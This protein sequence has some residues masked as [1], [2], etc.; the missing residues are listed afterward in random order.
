MPYNVVEDLAKVPAHMTLLDALRTPAQFENLSRVLQ[1]PLT[2]RIEQRLPLSKESTSQP[3]EAYDVIDLDPGVPPFYISVLIFDFVLHNCVADTGARHNVMPLRVMRRLGLECTGPCKDLLALDSRTVETIGYIKDLP[4][5]YDQAPEVSM[6]INVI[7]A[8]IPEA[9]GMLLGREWSTRV[10]NGRYFMEGTHFTFPHKGV[11]VVIKREPKYREQVIPASY[12][13]KHVSF[14]DTGMGTYAV[15]SEEDVHAPPSESEEMVWS[16]DFDGAKSKSGSGAGVLLCDSKGNAI[17]FSFR[18]EFPNTNNMAEYEA[19]V[20]GLQKAL[21]LGIRH[22]LVSG[23]SELVVNQIRGKYEVHNP[24]LK[25]YHR[26]AK[27]LIERFL[28]FNI[29][30]VP[31]AANHVADTLALAGSC[32]SS[33]FVKSIEDIQVQI[34]HRPALP[35]NVDSWQVFDTDEQICRF[36]QNKE[37][38]EDLHINHELEEET[39]NM[40]QLKTNKIPPGLSVLESMFDSDDATTSAPSI[41]SESVRKVQ[42]AIPVN[43]GSEKDPKLV[44]IG[45]QCSPS[46]VTQVTGLLTEFK[47]VFAW[48][49]QDLKVFDMQ[50]I[51]H[52]IPIIPDS[53]PY[54]QRQRK[55]NPVLE[56]TIKAELDKMEASG[57]IYHVRYSQ[58][59]SNLVPVR[60]KT[61]DI[62]LCVDFRH[63]N[64]VSLKDNYPVPPMEEILQQVSGSQMMSLLDGFSG[65]NQIAL[66][67]SDSHKTTFTTRWGTY[68]YNKMPFGLINA[69]NTFQRAMAIA[70]RGLLGKVIVVYFDDLTV[71]S[72]ERGSHFDHLRQVLLRCRRFGIS[73]NPK[74]TIF[75]VMEGKLLG[76]IVSPEGVKV[77]PER[78]VAIQRLPLP[79]NKKEMQSFFGKVNFLRRFIP[80]FAQVAKP[81]N[82]LMKKDIRF[83]WDPPTRQAFESIKQSIAFAPLLVS[84]DPSKDFVMYTNSSE[85]TISAIL[86]Q[87]DHEENLRPIAF[88]SQNLKPH[89]LNY[90]PLEKHG[91]SLYKTLE[92]VRHYIQGHKVQVFVPTSLLVT[93]LNQTE[94]HSKWSKWIMRMQ[95]YD[96]EIKPTKTIRGTGLAGLLTRSH[97]SVIVEPPQV[98]DLIAFEEVVNEIELASQPWYGP[99]IYFLINGVCPPDMD[100]KA[101]RTLR[102]QI[103]RYVLQGQ[104]LYRRNL[105]GV[106]SRCLTP[107]Q[108][109]MALEQCH[110]GVCGGHFSAKTT[111]A[112]VLHAGYFWPSLHKDAHLLVRKCEACQRFTGKQKLAALPLRP[113]EVQVPFARWGMDF[114]GP[115]S[116]PSSAGHVFILTATDYFTKWAEAIALRNATSQQVVEFVEC[117]I[118]SRFGTPAEILTDNGS[119]FMSEV[120]LHLGVTYGIQL[121]RS[122]TYYPQGNGLAES[123]NKNLIRILKRTVKDNKRDWHTKLNFALWADRITPKTATGQS[124]YALVYGTPAVLPVHLQI[125]ALR[126]AI[127]EAEDDFQPLQHR[128]DT[129][130]ELEEVRKDAFQHLQKKQDIVKRSFDKRATM[131]N[132]KV[133]DDVLLWDKAHEAPS[134]HR[135]F[136]SLWLGPY[137]IY[138]V[139]G[140][141]AFRLKTLDGEP[142]QFPVNGR[143]LKFFYS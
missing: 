29:Q 72:K 122:S 6:L 79:T 97:P 140:T 139:L 33:D 92:Q 129:L 113:I 59:V 69:G 14:Q 93:A 7:V 142:L 3:R 109:Q 102:L 87:K 51:V 9:Y 53:K 1:A 11:E 78:V 2:P 134:K 101:K 84:P 116:P 86:L 108:A 111:A 23:D 119:A 42:E 12:N 25:Q 106:L 54:R 68:A 40:I 136:D 43:L 110:S 46:E 10:K 60:K 45:A 15:L 19:L 4:I 5:A 115:I 117:N 132:Y 105:D 50:E 20:Q 98:D 100:T 64:R 112:K 85:E 28:S 120:M 80:D 38:F 35:D 96:L 70:F 61:G 62:R 56:Q 143:H 73:L 125:P 8:D 124:P 137:T 77:D 71:F 13:T 66:D 94:L 24:R 121:F 76:H 26:R 22:L 135:K 52:A 44:Y 114:I 32:F 58:W 65:Y 127:A 34:L 47:D 128:L 126:L 90:S 75:G 31:R 130:L 17:P 103:V 16:M 74:K 118:L 123:T 104:V 18:L 37:E 99:I 138:E 95:E 89:Q 141:N 63:L 36:L 27:E 131:V 107:D 91:Y 21:G 67:P 81:L 55:N 133:G 57:V 83:K 82:Q 30:A 48:S 39:G 41:D 49:Y 88:V